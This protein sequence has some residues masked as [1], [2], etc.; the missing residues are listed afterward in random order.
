MTVT[1]EGWPLVP[2]AEKK[3]TV[4]TVAVPLPADRAARVSVNSFGIGGTNAHAI[5][6][7]YRGNVQGKSAPPADDPVLLLHSANTA[8]SLQQAMDNYHDFATRRSQSLYDTGYTLA[9]HR[10]GLPH[11]GFSIVDKSGIVQ[12]SGQGPTTSK[13]PEVS[14]VFSGQ[15]GQWAQ[16]GQILIEN[17]AAVREDLLKMDA[18]LQ[19]LAQ[20]PAWSILGTR[21]RPPRGCR[22][23]HC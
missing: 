19:G 10:E 7:A 22:V 21:R 1:D 17:D 2:F 18:I 13:M 9:V 5:V 11:R 3:L 4:S 8:K 23:I 20:P 16:M 6:E 14:L 12:V 15:G